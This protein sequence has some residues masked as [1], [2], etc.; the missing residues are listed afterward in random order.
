MKR[1]IIKHGSSMNNKMRQTFPG[2][3]AIHNHI[4]IFSR[5][6]HGKLS[7]WEINFL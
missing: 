5:T 7:T 4:D 1:V 6:H 3:E 2:R